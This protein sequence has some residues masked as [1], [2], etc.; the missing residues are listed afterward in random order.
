MEAGLTY[1]EGE[2]LVRLYEYQGKQIFSKEGISVPD[3]KIAETPEQAQSI[4]EEL[5]EALAVKA[6]VKT[7]RRGLI[8]AIRYADSPE[9]TYKVARELLGTKVYGLPVEV[10]LVERKIEIKKEFY[11]SLMSDQRAKKPVCIVSTIGG[12]AIEEVAKEHPD[13][14]V[15]QHI[16]ILRGLKDYEARN[17]I[18][19]LPKVSSHEIASLGNVLINL[20]NIYCHYDCKLAEINPLALSED[21][22]LIALDARV[23]IDDDALYRHPELGLN[24][25]EEVGRQ[26]TLLEIAAGKI[27]EKDF[28]GTAHFV[29]IDP[30]GSYCKELNKTPIG[31]DCVGTG[32]SLTTLD[33]LADLGYMPV[34]FADTS[35]NPTG[36]KLYKITKII[37]SQPHIQG[38]LFVSCVS[39]QQLD[40][41]ARG[42]IKALKEL[43]TKTGGKPNI[44]MVFCIRGAWEEDA[45]RLFQEHE[46]TDSQWVCLLGSGSTEADAARKFHELYQRWKKETGGLEP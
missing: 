5:K 38:Y 37:L 1:T 35:G 3:G 13:L 27:D 11:M 29:Q 12:I 21:G 36:S 32:A 25:V 44:P 30:D 23:E 9:E 34:N 4:A 22:K 6:Q 24:R 8:N 28:R 40:N 2:I 26:E 16:N 39:S 33:E 14:I 19:R 17:I 18:R 7:G 31:F 15:K 46:I 45:H 43:Y 41:T 42:I 10:V 20:Y